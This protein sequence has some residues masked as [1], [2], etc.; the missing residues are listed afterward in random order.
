MSYYPHN[1]PIMTSAPQGDGE[2]SLDIPRDSTASHS[3]T[4]IAAV[5]TIGEGSR[6]NSPVAD[7][8]RPSVNMPTH[9]GMLAHHTAMPSHPDAAY[10][11]DRVSGDG[12]EM[13]RLSGGSGGMDIGGSIIPNMPPSPPPTSHSSGVAV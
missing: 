7:M 1:Q 5:T 9:P 2:P 4:L 3:N 13:G 6:T 8:P 10:V 11:R 12:S